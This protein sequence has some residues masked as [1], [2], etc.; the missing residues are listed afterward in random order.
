MSDPPEQKARDMLERMGVEDAQSFT[1]GD[2]VELADLIAGTPKPAAPQPWHP[3]SQL[4]GHQ[5]MVLDLLQQ[6][7]TAVL[8]EQIAQ[9]GYRQMFD[10]AD[11]AAWVNRTT[12]KLIME[13]N[14]SGWSFGFDPSSEAR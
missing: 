12:A 1:A 10:D 14:H 8:D 11:R 9:Y 2:L 5:K 7:V 6:Q 4:D 13:L 3:R